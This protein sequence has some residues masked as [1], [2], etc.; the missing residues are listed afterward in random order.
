MT[1]KGSQCEVG[2]Y[3]C[4]ENPDRKASPLPPRGPDSGFIL[5]APGRRVGLR[6]PLDTEGS[7]S[8]WQRRLALSQFQGTVWA[9][10]SQ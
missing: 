1:H 8:S 9:R 2:G 5:A 10:G 3:P 6:F 4:L 7:T